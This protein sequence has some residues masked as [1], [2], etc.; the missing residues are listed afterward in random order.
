MVGLFKPIVEKFNKNRI[1]IR[2]FDKIKESS[3]LDPITQETAEVRSADALILTATTI[4][5]GT[6]MDLVGH[7][8]EKCDIFLLGPSAIMDRDM[9]RYKNIKRIFGAVFEPWD[10]RV[11]DTIKEGFGTQKFIRYG[12]KVTLL[13]GP[14]LS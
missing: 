1:A 12:R 14:T 4:F 13:P 2:V 7:S 9:F 3:L 10:E 8:G 11:L 5:N 6:F